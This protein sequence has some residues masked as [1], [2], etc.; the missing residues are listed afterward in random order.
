MLHCS[1]FTANDA[2]ALQQL[3]TDPAIRIRKLDK[4]ILQALGKMSGEVLS[5]PPARTT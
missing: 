3:A 5:R 4:S 1:E 2:V